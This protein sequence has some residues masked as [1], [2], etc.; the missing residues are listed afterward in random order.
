MLKWCQVVGL[1]QM[2]PKI[3]FWYYE[4]YIQTPNLRFTIEL[5]PRPLPAFGSSGEE[6]NM[7][8]DPMV[9]CQWFPSIDAELMGSSV[10]GVSL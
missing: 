2:S 5:I 7:P 3:N 4:L 9:F 1:A 8:V 10:V 6:A